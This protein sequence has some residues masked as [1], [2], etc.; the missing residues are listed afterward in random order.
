VPAVEELGRPTR[1]SRG[2]A[3]RGIRWGLGEVV[4]GGIE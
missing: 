3:V 4:Q 2:E 1:P